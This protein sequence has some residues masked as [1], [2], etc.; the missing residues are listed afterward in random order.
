MAFF[1][2]FPAFQKKEKTE[3]RKVSFSL[4]PLV[5]FDVCN[6]KVSCFPWFKFIEKRK[7]CILSCSIIF[8]IQHLR[9]ISLNDDKKMTSL[10]I[11]RGKRER[12]RRMLCHLFFYSFSSSS[13]SEMSLWFLTRRNMFSFFFKR[14]VWKW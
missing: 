13:Q 8:H 6:R 10:I 12:E 3:R 7:S 1:P 2:S 5:C 9:T 4:V 11:T 14:C